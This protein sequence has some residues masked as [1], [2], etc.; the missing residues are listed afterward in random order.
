[1]TSS[2]AAHGRGGDNAPGLM[3]E[4]YCGGI[5]LLVI[6][7]EEGLGD[8]NWVCCYGFCSFLVFPVS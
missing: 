1:M 8:S 7:L 5:L 3:C 4:K 2:T 6:H